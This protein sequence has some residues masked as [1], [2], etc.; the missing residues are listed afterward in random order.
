MAEFFR[1]RSIDALLGKHRELE[2]QTIY[3]ASPEELN[4]PMEGLQDIVWNG[5]EIVWTN[6][7]KHYIF[8]LNRSCLVLRLIDSY[9]KFD[10]NSIPILERWD[11]MRFP[12]EKSLFDDI[13]DRFY[14]LPYTQEIIEAAA[15][16]RRKVRYNEILYYFQIIHFVLLD[17]IRKSYIDH[18][19]VSESQVTNNLEHFIL[20]V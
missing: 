20:E 18:G 19:I 13:W 5:D 4:D 11:Q 7:F 2:E 1:F 16:T 14:N 10:V 6:F 17:E 12:I 3:F 15:N 9:Q 8:C